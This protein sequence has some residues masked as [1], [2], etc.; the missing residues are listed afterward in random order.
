MYLLHIKERVCSNF[1]PDDC[2]VNKV[3]QPLICGKW[4]AQVT[5]VQVFENVDDKTLSPQCSLFSFEMVGSLPS[6]ELV[7]RSSLAPVWLTNERG[8]RSGWQALQRVD[9]LTKPGTYEGMLE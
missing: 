5:F 1:F 3:R 6:K 7:K 2:T 4:A 8:F 9:H